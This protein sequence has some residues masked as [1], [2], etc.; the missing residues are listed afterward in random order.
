MSRFRV[1]VVGAGWAADGHTVGFN[2]DPR[3]RVVGI[4]NRTR[5]RGEALARRHGVPHVVST[6]EELLSLELD[7][8]ALTTPG[9]YHCEAGLAALEAGCH[10]IC[11]KPM[12]MSADEAGQMLRL[13]EEKGLAGGMAFTWRYP[14][15]YQRMRELIAEGK[16]GR[17][18]E[19]HVYCMSPMGEV[20]ADGWMSRLEEGG[21]ILYQLAPHEID[22]ARGLLGLDAERVCGREKHVVKKAAKVPGVKYFLEMMR[23]RPEK[24]LEQYELVEATADNGY[25]FLVDYE[26]DVK[27]AFRAG[28]GRAEHGGRV[29]EAYGDRGTLILR[30]RELLLGGYSGGGF[31]RVEAAER[32]REGSAHLP[33]LHRL[34]AE[35]ISDFLDLAEGKE[36]AVPTFLDGYRGQQI[37]D[38]VRA[39][40]REGRWV[41]IDV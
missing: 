16:I 27:A 15:R 18:R 22:R 30:E 20:S 6:A 21:G 10:V 38:A 32:F 5:E 39:S 34:W 19:L 40:S 24:P 7:V 13:A 3:A 37:I 11:E 1:G 36:S 35:L 17:V 12:A 41:E 28:A 29:V 14:G 31:E 25:D 33:Y 4:A 23:W 8:V 2:L 9:R 26:A